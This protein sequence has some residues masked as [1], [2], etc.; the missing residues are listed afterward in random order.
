MS[1]I[2]APFNYQRSFWDKL[3]GG[4]QYQQLPTQSPDQQQFM[5]Q[6]FAL[7][8]GQGFGGA[9]GAL[10]YYKNLLEGDSSAFEAPLMREFQEQIVPGIAERFSGMGAQRSSAFGQQLGAAGAGLEEK[11]AALRAGLKGQGAQGL[12]GAFGQLGGLGLGQQPF[13]YVEK[14]SPLMQFL[15][16][17]I[18][19][20]ARGFGGGF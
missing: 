17:I 10:D 20:A 14:Q 16:Q 2:V 12:L 4:S 11:L 1:S 18:G 3:F 7:L 9:S 15:A 6:L 8:G 5:K 19:G 13:G